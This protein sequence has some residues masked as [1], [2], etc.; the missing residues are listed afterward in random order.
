MISFFFNKIV[1]H[2]TFVDSSRAISSGCNMEF[3]TLSY[4]PSKHSEIFHFILLME[5]ILIFQRVVK[6]SIK[7]KIC[8]I[9]CCPLFIQ[10]YFFIQV[11]K[12]V[13]YLLS[14]SLKGWSGFLPHESRQDFDCFS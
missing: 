12:N 3:H 7:F 1:H 11:L 8:K 2:F 5:Y 6:F 4:V 13:T 9:P 14:V 10:V